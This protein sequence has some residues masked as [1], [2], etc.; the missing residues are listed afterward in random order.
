MVCFHS[1][2]RLLAG[3]IHPGEVAIWDVAERRIVDVLSAPAPVA[4]LAA[5]TDGDVI[6]LAGGE[7]VF[8]AHELPVTGRQ[9]AP[10]P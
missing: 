6:L 3:V 10:T 7:A 8:M 4:A 5:T 2:G 9:P 1:G